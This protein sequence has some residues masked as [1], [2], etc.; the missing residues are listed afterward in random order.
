MEAIST[1][2]LCI[3]F[4]NSP[5]LPV[6]TL[7]AGILAQD[8]NLAASLVTIDS[9]RIKVIFYNYYFSQQAHF[10]DYEVKVYSSDDVVSLSIIGRNEVRH[11]SSE[12]VAYNR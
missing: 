8:E 4:L 5:W 1:S 10:V 3:F 6:K 2:S 12:S 11:R 9:R 7:S